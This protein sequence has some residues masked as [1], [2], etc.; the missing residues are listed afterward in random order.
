MEHKK[1]VHKTSVESL[2]MFSDDTGTK[3]CSGTKRKPKCMPFDASG[4]TQWN[5]PFHKRM[6]DLVYI[7]NN[8][9]LSQVGQELHD[10]CMV[11]HQVEDLES[12]W[13]TNGL[14]CICYA[15]KMIITI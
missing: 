4:R 9:N 11:C 12:N 6:Y 15:A 10:F 14:C 5:L 13:I 1:V 3:T 7:F 8:E 2:S